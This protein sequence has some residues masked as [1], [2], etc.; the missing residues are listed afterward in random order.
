M[1]DN[2]Y[3][4]N[5]AP[6]KGGGNKTPKETPTKSKEKNTAINQILSGEFLTKEFVINNLNYIFFIFLL[7][8]LMVAKGYYVKQIND[9]TNQLQIQLDQNSADYIEAKLQIES[10]TQRSILV[11]K[12]KANEL[13]ESQKSIRV[14]RVNNK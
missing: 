6:L 12:L 2:E 8:M 1:K 9:R 13:K 14:I 7:L 11:E 10:L 5:L 4:E 3:I